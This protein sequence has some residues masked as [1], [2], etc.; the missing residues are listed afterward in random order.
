M[1]ECV[2]AQ[3]HSGVNPLLQQRNPPVLFACYLQLAF[4]DKGDDRNAMRFQDAQDFFCGAPSPRQ[5]LLVDSD[6]G[7]IIKRHCH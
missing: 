3:N 7:Q 2:I 1:R 4:I 6:I 5:T